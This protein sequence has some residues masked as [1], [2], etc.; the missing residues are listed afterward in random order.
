MTKVHDPQGPFLHR[1]NK[2]FIVC[3]VISLFV[4]PVF[5]YAP[6]VDAKNLCLSLDQKLEITVCV[7]RSFLD[8]LYVFHIVLEF[9]TGFVAPS[10]RLFGRGEVIGDGR[11]ICTR[12]L[13]SYFILDIVSILPLPQV[14]LITIV[15]AP[16]SLATKDLFK[17]V[18]LA[19]FITRILRIYPYTRRSIKVHAN[20]DERPGLQPFTISSYA[21]LPVM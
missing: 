10:S 6:V 7:L 16:T 4:D 19:Q 3:C 14:N 9:R 17:M 11:A 5:F 15:N 13:S 18:I 21:F 1:C 8:I 20:L 12:Y 2:I